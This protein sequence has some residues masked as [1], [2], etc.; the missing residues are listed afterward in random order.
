MVNDQVVLAKFFPEYMPKQTIVH[1]ALDCVA[2]ATSIGYPNRL[3]CCKL[4]DKCGGVGFC[5]VD[6]VLGRDMTLF[7]K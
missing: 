6:E 7:N 1:N 2:F 3:I 5:V 4:T